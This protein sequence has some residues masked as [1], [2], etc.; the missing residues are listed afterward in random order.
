MEPNSKRLK[1]E[2]IR[3]TKVAY[4]REL[5][6]AL[7]NLVRK[8]EEWKIGDINGIQLNE[9]IHRYHQDTAKELWSKYIPNSFYD[10]LVVQALVAGVLKSDDLGPELHEFLQPKIKF[11]KSGH[12]KET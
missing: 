2:M 3:L 11:F 1:S 9:T 8:F 6:S 12:S 4:E 5:S 7:Q 10:L